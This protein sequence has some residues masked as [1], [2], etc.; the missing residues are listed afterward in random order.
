MQFITRTRFIA[1]V[2]LALAGTSLGGCAANAEGQVDVAEGQDGADNVAGSDELTGNFAVGT[3]LVT[4]TRARLRKGPSLNDEILTVI[5]KGTTVFSA[6]AAPR[7]SA[8]GNW[9]GITSNGKTGWMSAKLLATPGSAG[10]TNPGGGTSPSPST[11]SSPQANTDGF[12]EFSWEERPG[13]ADYTTINW[14]ERSIGSERA[15]TFDRTQAQ[16]LQGSG[17]LNGGLCANA[18]KLLGCY[19][20]AVSRERSKGSAFLR[21]VDRQ[22]LNPIRV[23]MAFSYQET[24][25]GKI[26]DSCSGGSCNGVGI[27][28]IITAFPNEGD[29]QTTLGVSDKRWDGISYNVLTNLSYSSRVLSEKVNSSSPPNLVELARAYNGNPDSSIRIPYGTKVQ[30]HYSDLGTCGIF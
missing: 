27:A 4:L 6:S 25:L 17:A 8:D 19:Q 21:W 12:C 2:A 13:Y 7:T 24:L 29:F 16:T 5:E 26:S 14:Y 30:Q 1:T 22:G 15:R 3:K 11:T 20:K 9:Y 23:K 10:T 18:K 28:Q